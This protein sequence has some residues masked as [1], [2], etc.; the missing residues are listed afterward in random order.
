VLP[1]EQHQLTED[2]GELQLQ[3]LPDLVATEPLGASATGVLEVGLGQ[4]AET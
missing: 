3:R 2:V 1:G 4:L